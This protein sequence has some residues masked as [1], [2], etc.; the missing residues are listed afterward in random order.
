MAQREKKR[1]ARE[2][3]RCYLVVVVQ[4]HV[5][6]LT[7][8]ST[9]ACL[10]PRDPLREGRPADAAFGSAKPPAVPVHR[11]WQHP[12][13]HVE[14]RKTSCGCGGGV[15]AERR[16]SLLA[17]GRRLWDHIVSFIERQPLVGDVAE[18]RGHHDDRPGSDERTGDAAA[19]DLA[20]PSGKEGGEA[21]SSRRSR[22]R[23]EG[24]GE[25]EYFEP[26]VEGRHRRRGEPGLRR[27]RL[28]QRDVGDG[29]CRREHADAALPAARVRG[30]R[31]E[32]VA[33][34]G[35][36]EDVGPQRVGALPGDDHRR[37]GLVLGPRRPA[38]G[39][40]RDDLTAADAGASGR[41]LWTSASAPRRERV[42][43]VV[44]AP[45]AAVIV[46]E[47]E[48]LMVLIKVGARSQIK[49]CHL[50]RVGEELIISKQ[51]RSIVAIRGVK[52][53][54]T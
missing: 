24:S 48:R 47:V 36:L 21:S 34:G 28:P 33:A 19:D 23:E 12:H 51:A 4:V 26:A 10:F 41:A 18:R 38:A 5:L 29:P 53:I 42:L 30:E 25:G 13:W 52:I 45:S 2:I 40:A 9:L 31:L 39:T 44:G 15:T 3:K 7:C 11:H 22:R 14:E 6:A 49:A 46:G 1:R 35:D 32:D 54:A 17:S 43:A 20:L 16:A 27:L 8:Q 37:L 50:S